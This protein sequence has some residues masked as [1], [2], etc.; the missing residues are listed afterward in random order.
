LSKIQ[1]F[2][3]TAFIILLGHPYP[4]GKTHSQI[5]QILIYRRGHSNVPDVQ[6]F[7]GVDCDTDNYLV[8]A[9]FRDRLAVN[10]PRKAKI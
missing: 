8:I 3:F 2:K 6:S 5:N 7:R 1:G 4:Y 9:N 10:K